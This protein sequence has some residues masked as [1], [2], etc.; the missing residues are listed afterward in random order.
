MIMMFLWMGFNSADEL[1]DVVTIGH[2]DGLG[3]CAGGGVKRLLDDIV[4]IS[5][6]GPAG[7]P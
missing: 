4:S 1:V 3:D 5:A 7:A 6:S 2:Q